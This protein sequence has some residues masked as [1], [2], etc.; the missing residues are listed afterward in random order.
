MSIAKPAVV[1]QREFEWS[2]L[3][4]FATATVAGTRFGVLYGRRRQGKTMLLQALA[5]ATSGFYWQARQQSAPQN[6]VSLST[7]LTAYIRPP[8]PIRF[9]SAANRS[10]SDRP[11]W[12]SAGNATKLTSW[13]WR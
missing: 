1:H 5:D 2:E 6:L 13:P 3:T 7:A 11:R 12:R 8:V 4:R 10:W 9:D